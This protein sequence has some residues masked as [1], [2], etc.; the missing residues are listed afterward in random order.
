MDFQVDMSPAGSQL[1]MTETQETARLELTDL[2]T[3]VHR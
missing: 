2:G 3:L 1:S